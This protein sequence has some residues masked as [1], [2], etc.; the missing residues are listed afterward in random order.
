MTLAE[1]VN[2]PPAGAVVVRDT[3]PSDPLVGWVRIVNV[4]SQV[5]T[6]PPVSV[7]ALGV[8]MTADVLTLPA[9][10]RSFCEAIVRLAVAVLESPLAASVTL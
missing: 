7:I 6:S 4:R 10:G 8:P 2:G 1:S 5:S 9:V 3:E